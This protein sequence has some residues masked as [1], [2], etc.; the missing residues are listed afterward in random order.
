MSLFGIG[1]GLLGISKADSR[2]LGFILVLGGGIIFLTNFNGYG[3]YGL[4]IMLIGFA[5]NLFYS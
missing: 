1:R 2:S 4:I 3:L 5:V